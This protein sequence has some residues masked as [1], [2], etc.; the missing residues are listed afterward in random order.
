MARIAA[1]LIVVSAFLG[2][3]ARTDAQTSEQAERLA[4]APQLVETRGPIMVRQL[5]EGTAAGVWKQIEPKLKAQYPGID[6]TTLN[7][8]RAQLEASFEELTANSMKEAPAIYA[9]HFTAS[10]LRELRDHPLIT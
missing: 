3:T 1:L 8:L 5:A 4:A 10:E 2:T 7:E 6:D 9:R